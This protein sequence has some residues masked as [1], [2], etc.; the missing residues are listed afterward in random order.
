MKN[1]WKLISLGIVLV[2]VGIMIITFAALN[3]WYMR[4]SPVTFLVLSLTAFEAGT[5]CIYYGRAHSNNN[6]TN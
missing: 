1:N 6:L 3:V 4:S 2:L 5:M